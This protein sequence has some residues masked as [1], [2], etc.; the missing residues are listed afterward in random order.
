MTTG[1]TIDTGPGIDLGDPVHRRETAKL[2]DLLPPPDLS[3]I[4]EAHNGLG[5]EVVG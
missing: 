3:F 1:R 5:W 4:M 2:R